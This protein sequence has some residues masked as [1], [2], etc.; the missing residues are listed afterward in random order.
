M[1]PSLRRS[2]HA[3]LRPGKSPERV[4]AAP[5]RCG[6]GW[7]CRSPRWRRPTKAP[8]GSGSSTPRSPSGPRRPYPPASGVPG[9]APKSRLLMYC[10]KLGARGLVTSYTMT[11]PIAL[12][13]DERIGAPR[14]RPTATPS[15]SGPL[16]SLRLS[17]SFAVVVAL[18]S[19]GRRR[20][21]DASR[22]PS[23]LSK[24]G[25]PCSSRS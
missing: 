11:P 4:T 18:K 14:Q 12:E 2:P 1:L 16:L 5:A 25:R 15:G 10:T 21:G 19:S 8:R 3:G 17:T 22:S 13:A 20:R 9:S 7:W 23:P 6:T 24:T